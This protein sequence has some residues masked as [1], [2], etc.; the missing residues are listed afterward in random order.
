MI[1]IIKK[2]LKIVGLKLGEFLVRGGEKRNHIKKLHVL[3]ILN[4]NT[5]NSI[6]IQ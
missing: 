3:C 2:A 1:I 4:M 6:N 5:T